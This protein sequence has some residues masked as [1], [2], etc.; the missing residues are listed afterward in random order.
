MLAVPS[1]RGRKRQRLLD[2]CDLSHGT[3]YNSNF[4]AI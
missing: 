4:A 3:L 2:V 1:L